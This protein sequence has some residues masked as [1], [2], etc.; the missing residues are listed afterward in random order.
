LPEIIEFNSMTA[1]KAGR[2]EFTK[3]KERKKKERK[4]ALGI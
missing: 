2:L 1:S 3:K 4:T